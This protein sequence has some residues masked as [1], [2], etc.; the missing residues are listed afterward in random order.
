[1]R[2][3]TGGVRLR[4]VEP[5]EP[6]GRCDHPSK[7]HAGAEYGSEC[8]IVSGKLWRGERVPRGMRAHQCFCDG[9]FLGASS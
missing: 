6:C 1:M 9:F 8:R 5:D 2:S 4:A 7:Y 3:E